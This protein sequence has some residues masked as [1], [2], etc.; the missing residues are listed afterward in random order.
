MVDEEGLKM[1]GECDLCDGPGAG[2]TE[3]DRSCHEQERTSV[4]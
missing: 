2:E 1:E 4:E 3:E